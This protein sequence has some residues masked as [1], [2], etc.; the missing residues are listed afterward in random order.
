[1]FKYEF[2]RLF[3]LF[4]MLLIVN[5]IMYVWANLRVCITTFKYAW[6]VEVTNQF[7]SSACPKPG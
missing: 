6:A 3:V 1:M 2:L 4:L 5:C 7:T